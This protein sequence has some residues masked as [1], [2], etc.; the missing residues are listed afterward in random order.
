[1]SDRVARAIDLLIQASRVSPPLR[2]AVGVIEGE[3]TRLI[4]S[5]QVLLERI[6][7]GRIRAE[8]LTAERDE[9]RAALKRR[10]VKRLKRGD[11]NDAPREYTSHEAAAWAAGWD[12]A[13]AALEDDDE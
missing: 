13:R 12:D 3:L 6:E 1:M 4:R 7:S 10:T 11:S 8:R 5:E 9:A 2:E